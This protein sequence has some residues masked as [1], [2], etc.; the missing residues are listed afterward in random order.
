MVVFR[1]FF[2]PVEKT[3]LVVEP[4]WFLLNVDSVSLLLQSESSFCSQDLFDSEDGLI[5]GLSLYLWYFVLFH[6][7]LQSGYEI[8][9]TLAPH[10]YVVLPHPVRA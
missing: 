6:G 7:S 10:S 4:T 2:R 9:C 1:C 3:V 5:S 8:I